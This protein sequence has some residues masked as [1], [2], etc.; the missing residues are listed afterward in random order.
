M[1]QSVALTSISETFPRERLRLLVQRPF[2]FIGVTRRLST[3]SA[4]IVEL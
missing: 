1:P 2:S 4:G 3:Q